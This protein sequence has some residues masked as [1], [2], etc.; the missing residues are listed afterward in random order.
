MRVCVCVGAWVRGC[1]RVCVCARARVC[2]C[3]RACVRACVSVCVYVSVRLSICVSVC[4]CAPVHLCACVPVSLGVFL[5]VSVRLSQG[6]LTTSNAGSWTLEPSKTS[7]T[8]PAK[9]KVPIRTLQ[10]C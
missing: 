10:P 3:V 6:R 2:V 8:D 9:V 5:S 7:S 1:V 4:V